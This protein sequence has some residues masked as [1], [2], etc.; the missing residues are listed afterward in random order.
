M[1]RLFVAIELPGG[2]RDA[3]GGTIGRLRAA[4][5]GDALR[6]VRP[7]SV[8]LTLK[9]LGSVEQERLPAI[10]TALRLGVRDAAPFEL[11]TGELGSFGGRRNLRV[12]WVDVLGDT[13]ALTTLAARVEA[14]LQPLGFPAE[15]RPF[16]AHLTL[17]RVRDDAPSPERERIHALLPRVES[18]VVPAFRVTSC[19]LMR[20]TLQRGGAVYEA[21]STYDLE[22]TAT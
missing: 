16:A 8:H 9:F 12:V 13:N 19:S 18:G 21:L 6:W 1:L 5:A 17:A 15:P 22:G 11:R 7:E 4:D 3:I 2:V 10:K 20:S 14:A